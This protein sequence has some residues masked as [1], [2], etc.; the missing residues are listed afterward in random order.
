M[1]VGVRTCAILLYMTHSTPSAPWVL[2]LIARLC[3][4]LNVLHLNCVLLKSLLGLAANL[5][6]TS[7]SIKRGLRGR[8][9]LTF[10]SSAV[11]FG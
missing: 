2:Y 11:C 10:C 5:Q 1:L 8:L 3:S 7:D 4:V 9:E 6:L